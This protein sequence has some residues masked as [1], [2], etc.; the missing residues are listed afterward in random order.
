MGDLFHGKVPTD[1]IAR[2]MA[3][4]ANNPR[5]VFQ[6]LTK[7]PARMVTLFSDPG[8]IES[9]EEH[10]TAQWAELGHGKPIPTTSVSDDGFHWPLD[11]VWAGVTVEDQRWAD[12]RM[13]L[14]LATPAKHR[15]VSA[16]PLLSPITFCT[17]PTPDASI[18]GTDGCPLHDTWLA[19]ID[20]DRLAAYGCDP[21][22]DLVIAGGESGPGARPMEPE[23][24]TDVA[25]QCETADVGFF[26]KQLGTVL[27]RRLGVPGK[28]ADPGLW[29]PSLPI[30]RGRLWR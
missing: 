3:V 10:R 16:E 8:F 19:G 12:K 15:F 14:L 18:Q 6:L 27:A 7:R 20:L 28:G 5:H 30:R 1:H 9:V 24:L 4:A 22:L 2:V 21:N 26:P 29:P 11:N 13:P 23:W 25:T 17:C